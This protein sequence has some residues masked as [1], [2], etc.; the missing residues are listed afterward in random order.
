M[1]VLIVIM[2]VSG[3]G[4]STIGIAIAK[5][6]NFTFIEADD[7]HPKENIEAMKEIKVAFYLIQGFVQSI[8]SDSANCLLSPYLYNLTAQRNKY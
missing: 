4:K 6:Y 5:K 2:G 1:P 3:S 8:V 7:F